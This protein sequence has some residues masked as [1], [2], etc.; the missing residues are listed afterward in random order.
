MA[1]AKKCDRCG[2]FYAYEDK[3]FSI[4]TSNEKIIYGLFLD[5]GVEWIRRQYD[6]CDDCARKL[7]DFL[8]NYESEG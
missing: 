4:D 2:K 7:Y 5:F 1:N 8:T 6:L 3:K